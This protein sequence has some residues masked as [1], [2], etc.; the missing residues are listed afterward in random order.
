M[1]Q[2]KVGTIPLPKLY[3]CENTQEASE[4]RIRGV[5]YII[6]PLGL[7]DVTIVKAVLY[8]TLVSK[9][10]KI[11]WDLVLGNEAINSSD[12]IMVR[13]PVEEEEPW[14]PL[15]GTVHEIDAYHRVN[16]GVDSAPGDP[17]TSMT[18]VNGGYRTA[19]GGL[20][21][22]DTLDKAIK[23]TEYK[24]V[25]ISNYIGDLG[26]YVS[27]EELQSLKLL[28]TFLDDIAEAIKVNIANTNW[29]DGYNKKLDCPIGHYQGSSAAPNLIVLD[30]SG[31][32][33]S[34]VAGTMISLIETLRHQC[35]ADL[36]I[37]S[38]RSEYWAANEELPSS[39]DLAYM[40]GG[41]NECKQFYSILR[42]HVLGK[43]WGNVIVFGD[44]DAPEDDRFKGYSS[45]WLKDNELQSTKIDRIMCFHTRY[46]EVPGYGLWAAKAAPKAE[47]TY[48][49]QWVMSMT[50]W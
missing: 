35:N 9:F 27:I 19:S 43:H 29:I 18:V 20:D 32:I 23:R 8:R 12:G 39:D 36:I 48:N 50:R 10:P 28:P 49:N 7:D 41:C 33:P 15:E 44:N 47:I 30:T 46:K 40:I 3:V 38:G 22:E 13:V 14:Q 2:L 24:R 42:K 26:W 34:G 5:P 37:T 11:R 4:C 45:S 17:S 31:S 21:P 1:H 6:R 25:S 16:P